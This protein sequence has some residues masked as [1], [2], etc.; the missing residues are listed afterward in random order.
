MKQINILLSGA[1]GPAAVNAIKSLRIAK[2]DVKI[3]AVDS[4]PL[5]AGFYLADSF[6]VVPSA[7]D[8]MFM[9]EIYKIIAEEK[10]NLIMPTSGFDIIPLSLHK[11]RLNEMGAE[12]FFSN[13]ATVDLCDNKLSFYK[14]IKARFPIPEF[15]LHHNVGYDYPV[16]IKPIWGKGSRNSY[17][18]ESATEVQHILSRHENM[19][20]CE[21]LPGKEYTVDVL[22]DLIGRPL[23]AVPRER[24]ETK[25]GVSYKGRVERNKKIEDICMLL[26]EYI[27]LLG[28]SCIQMKEDKSG[29][30]K[31]IEANPRMG[32]G[33]IMATLAG[34]NIP[35]LILKLY[36]GETISKRDLRFKDITVMRYYEEIVLAE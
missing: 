15:S 8:G 28:P 35:H 12:C 1:G 19:L 33:T 10:I 25:A 34:M 22:S 5:S 32:G 14:R 23:C 31:F 30:L 29:E 26:A 21:Y 27:G 3:I 16:F 17:L 20:I 4:N 11:S 36:N 24:I 13:Y 18:C 9:N 2:L 7:N 6:R